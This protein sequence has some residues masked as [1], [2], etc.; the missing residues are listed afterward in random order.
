MFIIFVKTNKTKQNIDSMN[1]LF[2]KSSENARKKRFKINRS[3]KVISNKIIAF[4]EIL[5]LKESKR[6]NREVADLLEVPNSTMQSWRKRKEDD[7]D[8]LEDF[9][10]SPPGIAFLQRIV[11][12]AFK[13]AKCGPSGI[14]GMQSF[15]HDSRLNRFVAS[16]TGAL[17]N[18]WIRCEEH[19]IQ[20]GESEEARLAKEMPERKITMGLDEMFR[21]RL[22]CLVAMEAVSNYI[23]LEKFTKDRTA[24][25]WKR[26][27]ENRM[28]GLNFKIRTVVSDLCGALACVTRSM[29]AIHSPD[30]F[31]GQQEISKATCCPLASQEKAAKKA[32]DKA[33]ENLRKLIKKPCR[34]I[35]EESRKQE[36]AIAVLEK[37]CENL[38]R[39]YEKKKNLRENTRAANKAMGKIYHPID[40]EKGKLQSSEE[41]EKKF[42]QQLSEIEGYVK[43]AKLSESSHKRIEKAKRAFNL[44]VNYF[45]N[46]LLVFWAFLT[47]MNLSSEQAIFFEKVVF[48]LC[49]L[50]LIW[51][52][53][54]KQEKEKYAEIL[55]SLQ[56]KFQSAE[57]LEEL[58]IEWKLKGIE[59]AE[60]FQRSTS[61][62]E[63]RN[64]GLSLLHHRLHRLSERSLK[65]LSIIYNFDI[66]RRDGTTSAERLFKSE[67]KNLFESLILN[68]RIPGRPSKQH[69]DQKKRFIGWEKRLAA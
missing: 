62:I 20:F 41:M 47:D 2:N 57:W 23:F 37:E 51:K 43:E 48:P 31:H 7:L 44:M 54:S 27:L 18:C 46:F 21:A 39:E 55:R 68:V 69:H 17:H 59:L 26:E 1:I 53:F 56:L 19:I 29:G 10:S 16:S 40:L 9:F 42:N 64:G 12:A 38:K 60:V 13:L 24:E 65:V 28:K 61:F 25:T 5:A 58:K 52:R 63:G 34:I 3:H 33:E 32:L 35:K 49:Y 30:L 22:P 6:S 8:E 14:P 36:K 50:E 15:L 66:R 11:L 4:E 45:K 67:H